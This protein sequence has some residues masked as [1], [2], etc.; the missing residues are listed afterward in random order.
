MFIIK[1]IVF[2]D[3]YKM[4]ERI[5]GESRLAFHFSKYS[6]SLYNN[7]IHIFLLVL[8]ERSK[9]SY[10]GLVE[11]ADTLNIKQMLGIQKLPHFT[12]LHKFLQKLDKTILSKLVRVCHK[13]LNCS[14]M[15]TAID[16]TGFDNTHPSMYYQNKYGI[17]KGYK[18]YINTHILTDTNTK[19]VLNIE[20]SPYKKHDSQFFT[21][22]IEPLKHKLR[23]VLG[24][25][26]YDSMQ[27]RE[28]CWNN[29]ITNHIDFRNFGEVIKDN[30]NRNKAKQ[31]FRRNI[32]HK[33]SIVESIISAIKRRFGDFVTAKTKDS[34]QKQ[35]II[36][37]IAYNITVL[38]KYKQNIFCLWIRILR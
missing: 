38:D 17:R 21:S 34:Q 28:Y 10:R 20:T 7:F 3:F 24:D 26:G 32:Y 35:V 29:N 13:I 2:N 16:G 37:A 11:L 36:K 33:R 12:T 5:F 14:N 18:N 23:C 31:R 9:Q 27:L 1:Q 4:V 15:L 25:K 22:L 6:N 8:K 19:L 30:K